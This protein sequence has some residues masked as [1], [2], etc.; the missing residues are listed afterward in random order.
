MTPPMHPDETP[1]DEPRSRPVP[2]VVIVGCGPRGLSALERV[3][4]HA[5][6]TGRRVKVDVVDPFPPGAGHVWRTRQS[7]RFL[8]NTPSLFP[9]VIA[10]DGALEVPPLEPLRG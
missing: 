7:P 2:R 8:M 1:D 6:A 10:A 3:V 5:A 4:A 9:T